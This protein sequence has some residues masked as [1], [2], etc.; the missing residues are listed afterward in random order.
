MEEAEGGLRLP[1]GP[2]RTVNHAIQF[3]SQ[4][5]QDYVRCHVRYDSEEI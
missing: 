3:D 5:L 4:R 2:R 1:L